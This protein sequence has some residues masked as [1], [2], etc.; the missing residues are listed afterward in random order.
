MNASNTRSVATQGINRLK[1]G[2]LGLSV[3]VGCAP[4]QTA[5]D[6]ASLSVG[7]LSAYV[8]EGREDF[9]GSG[10]FEGIV[11][12]EWGAVGVEL[13]QLTALENDGSEWDFT[14]ATGG[15]WERLEWSLGF[16][17]L[18]YD[19]AGDRCRDEELAGEVAWSLGER[20]VLAAD[21]VFSFDAQGTHWNVGLAYVVPTAS[22]VEFELYGTISYEAG[23]RSPGFSGWDHATLGAAVSAPISERLELSG[24]LETTFALD[25][26]KFD[27][28]GDQFYGGLALT[29][30]F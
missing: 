27:G 15:A 4:G 13:Y 9:G 22:D 10:S 5:W 21:G 29:T 28:G 11:A 1:A 19:Y 24:F 18:R 25:G 30:K 6:E 16:T 23:Y 12:A 7:L 2:L 14:L 17:H 3:V 26:V 20:W 8:S